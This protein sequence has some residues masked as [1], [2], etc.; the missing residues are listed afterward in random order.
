MNDYESIAFDESIFRAY[1]ASSLSQKEANVKPASPKKIKDVGIR[2]SSG[3]R[4]MRV[5]RSPGVHVSKKKTAL[6]KLLGVALTGGFKE[7]A[8]KLVRTKCSNSIIRSYLQLDEEFPSYTHPRIADFE[9]VDVCENNKTS[10]CNRQEVL[11]IKKVFDD[12]RDK[13]RTLMKKFRKIVIKMGEWPTNS[14]APSR[15]ST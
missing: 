4:D 5:L 11:E 15:A 1:N 13:I 2:A 9:M 6:E 12:K 14:Q 8:R 3:S 10:C 7:D